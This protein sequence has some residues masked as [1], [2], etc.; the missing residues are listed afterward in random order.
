MTTD[1]LLSGLRVLDFGRYIAGPFCACLLGDL[2][3]DVIRIE[4]VDGGEDRFVSPMAE[5]GDAGAMFLHVNRN[6]RGLTLNP[7]TEAGRAVVGRLAA[8]ADVVVANLPDATLASMGLDY[9]SLRR[10]RPDIVLTTVSAFGSAGPYADRVGF[11]GIGQAMCG[12][13]HLAGEP[14]QPTKSYV[15]WV[16]FG[17]AS[18][19]AFGTLAALFE[20]ARTGRGQHVEGALLR[21]ALTF[22]DYLLIEQELHHLDRRA[23]L[24]R[25]QTAAPADIFKTADGWLMVQVVGQPLFTRWARLVGADDWLDDARFVDDESRGRHGEEVSARMAT[26]CAT[27]TTEEALAQLEAARVPAGPVYSPQQVLDDPHVQAMG[28]LERVSYPG[29][30]RPAPLAATPVRLSVTP[31]T[32]RCRAPMLGEHTEEILTELGYQPDE[33]AAMRAAGAA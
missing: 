21:T 25:G 23:T 5:G 17:T 12:S 7:M 29:L 13:V 6:K 19:A 24:N 9:D 11:D 1:G 18:L 27:R 8:T 32:I 10:H 33:I 15:P 31:G 2:G 20:R 3:A 22:A 28:F 26:W 4:K 16:D 30:P 14:D